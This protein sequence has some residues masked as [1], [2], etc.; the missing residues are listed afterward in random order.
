MA[1]GFDPPVIVVDQEQ[2]VLGVRARDRQD[3]AQLAPGDT[4]VHLLA[5]RIEAKIVIHSG[6]LLGMR[7]GD[8]DQ[9]SGLLGT[10]R[11][12]LLAKD[13]LARLEGALGM[14]EVDIIGRGDVHGADGRIGKQLVERAIDLGNAQPLGKRSRPFGADIEQAADHDADPPQ[15]LGMN[16][17]NET[18]ANQRDPGRIGQNV[19]C[20]HWR[21]FLLLAAEVWGLAAPSF[22]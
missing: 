20:T 21:V 22:F 17:S 12:R 14:L 13:V 5:E 11:Q 3:P 10:D 19:R 1:I 4:G 6:R 8:F 2:P 16:R 18:A 7:R 9:L 15:C